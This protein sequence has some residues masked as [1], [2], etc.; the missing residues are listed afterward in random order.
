M[1]NPYFLT[2]KF[3]GKPVHYTLNVSG[4]R[5]SGYMLNKVLEQYPNGLPDYILP[6]FCNTGKEREETLAFVR[7][8]GANWGVNIVWLEYDF[9]KSA[10]GVKGS[11]RRLSHVVDFDTA[12]RDGQPFETLLKAKGQLP[13]VVQRFCTQELKVKTV[14]RYVYRVLKW[15]KKDTV[16]V[17]GIRRDE[18]KR[19]GKGIL[20]GC[21]IHYPLY[22]AGVN[23][24]DVD[25]F[26]CD[27]PFDLGID[28]DLSNCDLC[29]LRGFETLT[30]IMQSEPERAAWWIKQEQVYQGTFDKRASYQ[31]LF[32]DAKEGK[33]QPSLFDGGVDCF[34]GD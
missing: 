3:R 22:M 7:D 30:N 29:F 4:G 5:S 8:M 34:C 28:S 31:K 13:N 14:E 9:D 16:T 11:P 2:P 6:V 21:N 27:Q 1:D 15:R 23:R 20:A 25:S 26:W 17:L 10:R 24:S 32:N 12:S 33:M 19:I 18:P